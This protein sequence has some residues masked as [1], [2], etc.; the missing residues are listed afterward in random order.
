MVLLMLILFL[1]LGLRVLR[2]LL[3]VVVLVVL[4]VLV[5]MEDMSSKFALTAVD[6]SNSL[7]VSLFSH[8]S[9][10]HRSPLSPLHTNSLID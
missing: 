3:V 6:L 8:L 4:V 7:F 5:C 2:V 1:V 10:H 9:L